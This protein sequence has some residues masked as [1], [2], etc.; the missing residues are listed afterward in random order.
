MTRELHHYLVCDQKWKQLQER[1]KTELEKFKQI[2]QTV[3]KLKF[4]LQRRLFADGCLAAG[5]TREMS[6]CA[7][8]SSIHDQQELVLFLDQLC[9]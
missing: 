7:L 3:D 8:S 6:L 5:R 9:S 2:E 1:K 4:I